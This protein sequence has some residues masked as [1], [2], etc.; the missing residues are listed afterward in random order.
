MKKKFIDAVLK[1]MKK[2]Y[3][4]DEVPVGAIIVKNNKIIAKAYNKKEKRQ[5]PLMH[6]EIIAIVKAAKKIKSWK[7]NECELYVS[8]EPCPMCKAVIEEARIGKVYYM[9]KS[10]YKTNSVDMIKMPFKNNAEDIMKKFFEKK[11]K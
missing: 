7:L 11:R 9:C 10:T 4:K 3:K 1:E 5:N 8:L 2:A 6:A